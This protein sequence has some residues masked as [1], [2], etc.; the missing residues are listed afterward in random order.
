[1]KE[2][3]KR[4]QELIHQI[5]RRLRE[6][7]ES[8]AEKRPEPGKW[9]KKEI[10]GHLIDSAANNHQR[11]V[12]AQLIESLAF[13]AYA[14]TSWV[15]VQ[16][17]QR[18]LWPALIE[19]WASFN[20]HLVHVLSRVP[21]EKWNNRCAIGDGQPVTLSFLAE[22]YVAHLEHHLVQLVPSRRAGRA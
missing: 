22:D 14:Q 1:M 16:G 19:L 7:S 6:I 5:P 8:E 2:T 17:Y 18:A 12:R 13:P 21:E 4:L 3:G 10:L 20:A 11:F 15:E 9:S